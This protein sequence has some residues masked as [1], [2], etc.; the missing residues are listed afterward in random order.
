M[1]R[2]FPLFL[3]A[4][5][6]AA[7]ATTPATPTDEAALAMTT[8]ETATAEAD[9]ALEGNPFFRES[10]LP[11]AM[12]PFDQ[13]KD[14]HYLPAYLQGM[15]QHLAEIAAIANNSEAP[16]FANTVVAMEQSGRLLVRVARVFR[17]LN[18]AHTNEA[19]QAVE[20]TVAPLYAAHFDAIYLNDL[21]FARLDS[22]YEQRASLGLDAESLRLL[23]RYHTD[24]VRAGARLDEAQKTRLRAINSEL[25]ELSTAFGQN[26][27]AET[28]QSAVLVDSL[29]ALAGLSDNDIASAATAAAAAG[30]EGK[31]LLALQNTTI[32]P[33]LNQMQNRALR[34]RIHRASISRGARDNAQDNRPL[35]VRMATLRAERA[36]LLGYSNAADYILEDQTAKNKEAVNEMLALLAPAAL[37]NAQRE[38]NEIQALIQ[39]QGES[40]GLEPWDWAYYAEQVR[41]ARYDLDENQL[42][43]YFELESVLVNGVFYSATQLFGITFVERFDLPVYH[44]DVRVWEVFDADG[45]PLGLFFGD[46]W[47][48]ESKRGGAWMNQYVLQSNLLGERPVVGN[49]LNVTKPPAGQPTLLTVREVETLFHEFGHAI[50][51][52]FSD[53]T[54]PRFGGTTVPRDF[55]EY[56]SQV[57][58]MWA[59]WPEVLT[60][61]AKHYEDGSPIPQEMI[62]KVMEGRQFNQGYATTEYVAAAIIDQA[63]HQSPSNAIPVDVAAFEEEALRQAGLLFA[64]V[65]PRYLSTYFNHVFSGGYSAG[66]YAYIWA[67]VLDADSVEWFKSNGGLTRENGQRL[68]EAVL[69]RGGSRDAMELYRAFAGRDPSIEP[70]LARRGLVMP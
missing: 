70:L 66:Y 3:G 29:E 58:E 59:F 69:S 48:R 56:P 19:M 55:V 53:V 1:V 17:N 22:L 60:H 12:P 10:T 50:H 8:E 28:N 13:I 61:Y 31:Y 36:E 2:F 27:L 54:Y 39:S 68:R 18:S 23:E 32:Q 14:E 51:G 42:K 5:I 46:F 41:K 38:A 33:I 7:C 57:Y 9:A 35:V 65:P 16:T 20:K 44:P 37:L 30:H 52:F 43:P 11:Y 24:F 64:P 63:W 62:D 34:E 67:E 47:A 40:F 25:A 21:L 26:V 15:E 4:S 45:S 6:L 49:H